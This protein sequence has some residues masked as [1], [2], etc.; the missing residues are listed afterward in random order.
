LD[1][2]GFSSVSNFSSTPLAEASTLAPSSPLDFSASHAFQHEEE[3]DYAGWANIRGTAT[4][5]IL[6]AL[7]AWSMDFLA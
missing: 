3:R 5:A 6:H 1:Y 4:F 2:T 7:V